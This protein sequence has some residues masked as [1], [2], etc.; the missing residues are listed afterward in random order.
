[1]SASRLFHAIVVVSVLG[2]PLVGACGAAREDDEGEAAAPET[3]TPVSLSDAGLAA[4]SE[5]ATEGGAAEDGAGKGPSSEVD[6]MGDG[7]VS[8][9]QGWPPTK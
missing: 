1:V 8:V 9:E 5:A 4:V 3:P 7:G 2:T 6:A